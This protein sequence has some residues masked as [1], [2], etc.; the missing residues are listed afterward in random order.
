[1]ALMFSNCSRH[2]TCYIVR[3]FVHAHCETQAIGSPH[4]AMVLMVIEDNS[5]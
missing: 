1:M 3:G 5:G 4:L 2:W